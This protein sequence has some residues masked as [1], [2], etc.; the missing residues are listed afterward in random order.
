MGA[1][2]PSRDT[3]IATAS[4]REGFLVA[5]GRFTTGTGRLPVDTQRFG[6]AIER[7]FRWWHV[8]QQVKEF[9]ALCGRHL[10]HDPVACFAATGSRRPR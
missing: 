4:T 10:R 8:P 7:A 6:Q 9:F 3:A 1:I 5:Q 2:T